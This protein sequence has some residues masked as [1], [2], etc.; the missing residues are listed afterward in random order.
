MIYVVRNAFMPRRAQLCVMCVC[1]FFT[2][3][4]CTM[5]LHNNFTI[6]KH[7]VK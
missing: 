3:E 2:L 6:D 1:T 4:N 5:H 7:V